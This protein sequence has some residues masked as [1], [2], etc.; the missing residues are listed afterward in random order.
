ML[1]MMREIT[2]LRKVKLNLSTA[3]SPPVSPSHSPSHSPASLS[4]RVCRRPQFQPSSLSFRMSFS[5][6]VKMR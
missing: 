2:L 4:I 1:T 5:L 6:M 3:R